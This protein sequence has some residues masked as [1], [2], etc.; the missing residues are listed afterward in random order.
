MC[1]SSQDEQWRPDLSEDD[2]LELVRKCVAQLGRRHALAAVGWQVMVV[3]ERGC[4]LAAM[5]DS[6]GRDA[7]F[8]DTSGFSSHSSLGSREESL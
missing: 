6:A 1:Y 3:D 4:R 5:L 2:A 7:H 8:D